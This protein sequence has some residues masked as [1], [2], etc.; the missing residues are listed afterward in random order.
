MKAIQLQNVTKKFGLVQALDNL[1]LEVDEGA[2]CGFI[3]PNGAGKSTSIRVLLNI[4]YPTA[5]TAQIFGMD[6][7]SQ[8]HEIKKITSYASSDVRLYPKLTIHEIIKIV[9]EFRN[10]VNIQ[11]KLSHYY[12]LFEMNPDKKIGTLSLG[13]KKKVALVASLIASPKLLILDEPSNGL[14]PLMHHRFFSEL[15]RLNASGTTIFLSSHD[16]KEVQN[17]CKNAI[18][19]KDGKV[20]AIENIETERSG[21]KVLSISGSVDEES[22]VQIGCSILEKTEMKI[23]FLVRDRMEEVLRLLADQSI[24]DFEIKNLDLDEKFLALYR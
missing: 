13:N 21:N 23:R 10:L 6:C 20:V 4:L 18:F 2:F 9:A 1:N 22:F 5:G 7:T 11:D 3:G 17:Y 8:S 24:N 16:L 15:Q 14:D 19:I 12:E